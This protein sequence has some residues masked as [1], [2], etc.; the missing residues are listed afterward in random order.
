M[1]DMLRS[2][3]DLAKAFTKFEDLSKLFE[4]IENEVRFI[5][6][7]NKTCVGDDEIGRNYHKQVDRPTK[8]LSELLTAMDTFILSAGFRGKQTQQV[9]DAADQNAADVA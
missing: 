2:S 4:K 6:E 8:N 3:Q 1:A 9:M 7:N 5:N